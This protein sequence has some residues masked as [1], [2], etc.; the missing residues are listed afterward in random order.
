MRFSLSKLLI[1]RPVA[2]REAEQ[3]KL[4]VWT[5]VPAMG[6]DGLASAAYGPEAALAVLAV[7]GP[8]SLGAIEPCH[9]RE[10]PRT[11]GTG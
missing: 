4:S 7:A 10:W 2:N 9:R 11:G 1:G 5:G 8:A 6:L 3:Q